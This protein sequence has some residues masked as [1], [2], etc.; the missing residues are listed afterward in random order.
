MEYKPGMMV[1]SIAGHDKAMMYVIIQESAEY[2]YV[3]DGRLK[4]VDRPKKKNKKHVQLIK[5]I[6]EEFAKKIANGSVIDNEDIR[7][8]LEKYK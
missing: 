1:K 3:C 6:S 7:K 8:I 2:V 4:L 5:T